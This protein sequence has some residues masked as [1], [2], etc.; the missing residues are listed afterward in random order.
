MGNVYLTA[1][2]E[3]LKFIFGTEAYWVRD[4]AESDRTNAHIILLARNIDGVHAI[5]DA[6]SEANYTGFYAVPRLDMELL[7][8]L[9]PQD[10]FCDYRMC[11]VLG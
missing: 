2:K 5:N 3:N 11:C 6:I 7:R 8:M 9:P 10:V 4:R 1:Q